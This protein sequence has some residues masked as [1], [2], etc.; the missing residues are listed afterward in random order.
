MSDIKIIR[1]MK[2]IVSIGLLIC[3][4]HYLAAQSIDENR[5]ERDL[6]VAK[7][8]LSTLLGQGSDMFFWGNRVDATYIP[9]YGVIFNIPEKTFF[10]IA[11]PGRHGAVIIGSTGEKEN[12]IIVPDEDIES[13]DFENPDIEEII[14][15]FLADYAD[16][17]GQLN[18]EDRIKVQQKSMWGKNFVN[19][20]SG[21]D[22]E[23]EVEPKGITAEVAKKDI[24]T[25]RQGK[26]S[27][28]E[29]DNRI[30]V[31]RSEEVEKVADLEMFANMIKSYYSPGISKT[32]FTEGKP[33]YEVLENFGVIFHIRTYSAYQDKELYVMPVL[34]EKE[35]SEEERNEII[36][37][38]YPRF[39]Q[40]L[41]EFIVDYG[42]T[43]RS[44]DADEVL[45]L[46]VKLTRCKECSIPS[47][48]DVTLKMSVLRDYDQ[49]KIS[50][51]KALAS[52]EIKKYE[53]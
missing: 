39:E 37:D 33:G 7:N 22:S 38:L 26:I 12:Q 34:G 28:D 8:V 52:I 31:S 9:G 40:E 16:I 19:V 47:D 10:R 36:E 6:E 23:M 29:F 4:S 50:R 13:E 43:I 45:V 44:L 18:A 30:K 42:R 5:M 46:K 11:R 2:R 1:I 3:A 27:R 24:S 53:Q 49:Q 32:F 51:D 25:Y 35:V 21:M 20:W 14:R 41:K 48:I 17:I 15:T